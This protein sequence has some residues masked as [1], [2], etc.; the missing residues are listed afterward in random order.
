V[1]LP[2][3]DYHRPSGLDEALRIVT[4]CGADFDFVAGGTDLLPNYKQRL[5]PRRHVI[6]LAGLPELLQIDWGGGNGGDRAGSGT[7]KAGARAGAAA[8]S[9]PGPLAP[10]GSIRIGA[11]VTL[12]R[13]VRDPRVKERIP[14]L[15]AAASQ[16]ASPLIQ[17]AATVGGNL[18]VETRCFFFNQFPGWRQSLGYCLKAEGDECWVVPQKSICYATYSGDL[19]PVLQVL[20]AV[21]VL[22][23]PSGRREVPVT[24]FYRP[25]G[26][27]KNF[28]ARDELIREIVVPA[29]ASR[30]KCAYRKL[31]IRDTIDFPSLG[32]AVAL[33]LENGRIETLRIA[34]TAID[35]VPLS[36]DEITGS[37]I[38]EKMT[39][40]LVEKIANEIEAKCRPL[41]NV[42]L[43]PP[44]R[45]KMVGVYTRQLLTELR[46]AASSPAS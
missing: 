5:N 24:R 10:G 6:S 44:Y 15:A 20:D 30:L 3:F 13:L 28:K 38:G 42:P 46:D 9:A 16:V 35:V 40:A 27:A 8:P 41:R 26:I 23:S 32:A 43:S 17:N 19:A 11:A 37:L 33:R 39:D 29:E 31:R 36:M 1:I 21:L 34:I 22:E 18:L 25:D 45:K 7:G 14:V 4:D 12:S 2:E